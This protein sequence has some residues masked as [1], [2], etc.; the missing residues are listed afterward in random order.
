MDG[1]ECAGKDLFPGSVACEE[2]Y[3]STGSRCVIF[4]ADFCCPVV[5]GECGEKN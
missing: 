1:V 5:C 2:V 4:G 3:K